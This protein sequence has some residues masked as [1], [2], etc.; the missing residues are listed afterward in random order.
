MLREHVNFRITKQL[1]IKCKIMGTRAIRLV[2]AVLTER[3]RE[4]LE[5]LSGDFRRV[6]LDNVEN[7]I[8]TMQ[9]FLEVSTFLYSGV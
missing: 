5:G 1:V 9:I 6:F 4:H 7:D 8:R 3:R 2:N